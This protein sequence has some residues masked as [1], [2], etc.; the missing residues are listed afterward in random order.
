MVGEATTDGVA[1]GKT[2]SDMGLKDGGDFIG[3]RQ[4]V[5]Q[6]RQL[7]QVCKS[8]EVTGTLGEQREES[9]QMRECVLGGEELG[10][11]A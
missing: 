5:E 3:R 6:P 9:R 1:L 7:E 11:R 10:N 4:R 8:K 2:G